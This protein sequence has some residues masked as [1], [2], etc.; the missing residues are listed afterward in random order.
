MYDSYGDGHN[1][2]AY[3]SRIDDDGYYDFEIDQMPYDVVATVGGGWTGYESA[4]GP[5]N[6]SNGLFIFGGIRMLPI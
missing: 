4:Y 3:M 6:L 5:F 2:D 1:G